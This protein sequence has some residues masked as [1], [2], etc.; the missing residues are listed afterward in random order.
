MNLLNPIQ[1]KS[2]FV[3]TNMEMLSNQLMR[4][5]KQYDEN[6]LLLAQANDEI[7]QI[8]VHPSAIEYKKQLVGGLKNDL[9]KMIEN[10]NGDLAAIDKT[11]LLG[12][13]NKIRPEIQ[14]LQR[15][16]ALAEEQRKITAELGPNAF[17]I[18]D[19]SDFNIWNRNPTQNYN[20]KDLRTYSARLD[21]QFGDRAKR[22]NQSGL[23][24]SGTDGVLQSSIVR[25]LAP[26]EIAQSTED[27]A[28]DLMKFDPE[29]A[30]YPEKARALAE[31]KARSMVG[32]TT[33]DFM[34]DPSYDPNASA[35]QGAAEESS[36]SLITG[37]YGSGEPNDFDEK[38]MDEGIAW[39]ESVN[40]ELN[41]YNKNPQQYVLERPL[42]PYGAMVYGKELNR[43]KKEAEDKY[44]GPMF[45]DLTKNYGMS[46]KE[47][48]QVVKK[49]RLS[50]PVSH[51]LWVRPNTESEKELIGNMKH[52]IVS[53]DLGS[54]LKYKGESD[55]GSDAANEKW[56]RES[57]YDKELKTAFGDGE[58]KEVEFNPSKGIIKFTTS[59]GSR[60][61]V[62][63]DKL[64]DVGTSELF[65][66]Y[67]K[68]ASV[69]E[70]EGPADSGDVDIAGKTYSAVKKYV[71]G[72]GYRTRYYETTGNK[73]ADEISM[74]RLT[75]H[76]FES[77]IISSRK[78]KIEPDKY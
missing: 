32:G 6:D 10:R 75:R 39:I 74:D 30:K 21:E 14:K 41:I 53:Q 58:V 62:P 13:I 3:P 67:K 36:A 18:N 20:V 56:I 17:I 40:D 65:T 15:H 22:V 23:Y 48:L 64:Q 46:S 42:N 45:Y 66:N 60:Y 59:D 12:K 11:E 71:K 51:K 29:L 19:I 16:N 24:K 4:K 52:S 72:V 76:V 73:K 49:E 38:S 2:M 25:G 61:G 28:Q 9:N 43:L 27:F 78:T 55:I 1:Y 63:F 35:K 47:A 8:P 33:F 57:V 34:N 31:A 54:I 68:L 50:K 44:G 26:A 77:A 69:D 7:A 5:E 70:G 37:R